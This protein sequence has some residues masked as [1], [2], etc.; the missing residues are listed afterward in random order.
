ME[1][2]N[3]LRS[4]QQPVYTPTSDERVLAIL[5][6]ALTFVSNIIAPLIIYLLKKDDSQYVAEQ[7]KES[8][9]FQLTVLLACF[10]LIMNII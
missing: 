9:N 2:K 6:H 10:V 8:L 4:G 7:A 1:E 5:A 3:Y